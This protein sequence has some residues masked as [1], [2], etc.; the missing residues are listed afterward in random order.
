MK[1]QY[2]L[3]VVDEG[4]ST[5]VISIS[6]WKASGSPQVVPSPTLLTTCDVHSHR[7]HGIVPSLPIFF[8]DKTVNIEVKIFD[9]NLDYNLLLGWN[10]IY[11]MDAIA[12]SLFRI[13]YFPHEG[14]IF[15]VD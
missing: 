6:C 2:F 1:D 7:P 5:C 12:S 10:W 13:L 3:I 14:M 11:E 9:T 8:G 4:A 15:I